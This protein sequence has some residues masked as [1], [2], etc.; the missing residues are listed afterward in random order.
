VITS[1]FRRLSMPLAVLVGGIVLSGCSGEENIPLKKVD[2]V[3]EK[4]KDFQET[5]KTFATKGSSSK[6][7]RDPT[8]VSKLPPSQ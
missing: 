7:G 8:G 2:M 3:L 5:R 6:I 4:P 1:I